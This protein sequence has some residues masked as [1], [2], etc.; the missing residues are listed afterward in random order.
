[1]HTRHSR[2]RR[3][4]GP[5]SN[6]PGFR[7]VIDEEGGSCAAAGAGEEGCP[8]SRVSPG[9]YYC[10]PQAAGSADL[11]AAVDWLAGLGIRDVVLAG[12]RFGSARVALYAAERRDACV[13]VLVHYAPTRGSSEYLPQAFGETRYAAEVERQRR[14]VADGREGEPTFIEIPFPPPGRQDD[15]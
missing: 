6:I 9:G 5:G 15:L 12:H 11:E 13:R 14:L 3:R 4:V 1:M 8:D 2:R 10:N 7:G